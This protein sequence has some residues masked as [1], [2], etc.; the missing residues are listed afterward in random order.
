[1]GIKTLYKKSDGSK[2][3]LSSSIGCYR[4]PFPW[5]TSKT[6][7]KYVINI[8]IKKHRKYFSIRL[9]IVLYLV[10]K[11]YTVYFD[12]IG[13]VG[14]RRFNLN[15]LELSLQEEFHVFNLFLNKECKIVQILE[16]YLKT[17]PFLL[18]L[19][20]VT[21]RKREPLSTMEDIL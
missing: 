3:F 6:V 10:V 13:V 18:P 9:T 21:E 11:K 15:F 4:Q 5:I 17:I 16:N 20:A 12:I 1:M 7:V 2:F 14:P 19:L 8:S